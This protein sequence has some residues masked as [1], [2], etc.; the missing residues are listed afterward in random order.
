MAEEK[1]PTRK[2]KTP[3]FRMSHPHILA[4][5]IDEEDPNKRSF[6][7]AMLYPP[8]DYRPGFEKQLRTALKQA[9]IDKF[10][11]DTKTWPKLDHKPD[12]V[13]KDFGAYNAERDKPLPGDW[14][15]WLMIRANA[16]E[17]YP[18][19]VV[20]PVKGA[21]GKF[22]VIKDDREVYGG[23]WARATI[24]AYFFK[25]KKQ[26]GVTFGLGNVQLLKHDT[27]FGGAVSAAEDDFDNASEDWADDGDWGDDDKAKAADK[28]DAQDDWN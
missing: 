12:D 26:K 18:P 13:L 5:R 3:P 4:V 23:R 1:S 24:D 6:Q 27:Q 14:T 17:K 8:G 10:G 25:S 21:D 16:Q 15:G 2:V 22:P 19:A 11:A 20:G 9:M 28:S 7:L